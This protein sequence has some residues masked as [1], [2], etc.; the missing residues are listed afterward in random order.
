M[1]RGLP[2]A[3][4]RAVRVSYIVYIYVLRTMYTYILYIVHLYAL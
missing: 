1:A 2:R 4:P 3:V